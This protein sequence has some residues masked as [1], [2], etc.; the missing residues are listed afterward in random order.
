MS[1]CRLN[2]YQRD[3]SRGAAIIFQKARHLSVLDSIYHDFVSGKNSRNQ[4]WQNNANQES[5]HGEIERQ[6]LIV[7]YIQSF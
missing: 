1:F 5:V 3:L 7:M 4:Q 6:G 2:W